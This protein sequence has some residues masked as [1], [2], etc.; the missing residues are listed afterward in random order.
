MDTAYQF[1]ALVQLASV[2]SRI[3]RLTIRREVT[4]CREYSSNTTFPS[5]RSRCERNIDHIP[6][7]SW[8]YAGSSE[9]YSR[10]QVRNKQQMS[11]FSVKWFFPHPKSA[12]NYQNLFMNFA[13]KE[14]KNFHAISNLK[15]LQLKNI[16]RREIFVLVIMIVLHFLCDPPILILFSFP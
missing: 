8:D 1:T 7:F 2:C 9:G 13:W 5:W 11:L 4:A 6:S 3:G 10:P 15:I 14:I 12:E 16:F